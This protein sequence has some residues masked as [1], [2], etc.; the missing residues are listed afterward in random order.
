VA[1][2]SGGVGSVASLRAENPKATI[3]A[4]RLQKKQI[5]SMTNS[6]STEASDLQIQHR[7]ASGWSLCTLPMALRSAPALQSIEN[8]IPQP[9]RR[10]T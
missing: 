1:F 10:K 3:P 4:P 5:G 7:A 9:K 8:L 2:G 6:S